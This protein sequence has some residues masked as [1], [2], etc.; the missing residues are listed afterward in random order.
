MKAVVAVSYELYELD[1][2]TNTVEPLAGSGT[3]GDSD[4][5][6]SSAVFG[7]VL[8]ICSDPNDANVVYF[9]SSPKFRKVDITT[10]RVRR[11]HRHQFPWPSEPLVLQLLQVPFC[12]VDCSY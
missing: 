2:I 3:Q 6:G 8:S 4:G 9:G 10:K 7:S 5:I 11:A 12:R 1:L